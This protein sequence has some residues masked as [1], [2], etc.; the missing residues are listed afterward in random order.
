MWLLANPL[1]LTKANFQYDIFY[2]SKVLD[3][4]AL[5]PKVLQNANP[6]PTPSPTIVESL[7]SSPSPTPLAGQSC[8]TKYYSMAICCLGALAV[9]LLVI[10][11]VLSYIYCGPG[12]KE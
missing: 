4:Q 12:N 6:I 10:I 2:T 5:Q 1:P 8:F 11:L 7:T 9:L 3:S